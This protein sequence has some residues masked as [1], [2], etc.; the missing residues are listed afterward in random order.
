MWERA[1]MEMTPHEL[2]ASLDH[3]QLMHNMM[4]GKFCMGAPII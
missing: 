4:T 3:F 1:Y 2:E